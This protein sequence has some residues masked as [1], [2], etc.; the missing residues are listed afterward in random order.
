MLMCL[1]K[2]NQSNQSAISIL[3][4]KFILT[5]LAY[6]NDLFEILHNI[7]NDDNIILPYY[8]S[9]LL[10]T[11]N[12]SYF[13]FMYFSVS[14]ACNFFLQFCLASL[15][16]VTLS[17]VRCRFICILGYLVDTLLQMQMVDSYTRQNV[18]TFLF[19]FFLHPMYMCACGKIDGQI[20][21]SLWQQSLP[22]PV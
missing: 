3:S 19:S 16:A 15:L 13:P 2:Q 9:R 18:G 12:T 10:H 11:I 8:I 22:L 5:I 14:V 20:L 21:Y 1:I 6:F 7:F 4:K 17:V